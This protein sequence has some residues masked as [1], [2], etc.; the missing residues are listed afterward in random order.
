MFTLRGKLVLLSSCCILALLLLLVDFGAL[1]PFTMR[2]WEAQQMASTAQLAAFDDVLGARQGWL[3][4]RMAQQLHAN[5]SQVNAATAMQTPTNQHQSEDDVLP[6]ICRNT[7]YKVQLCCFVQN[8]ADSRTSTDTAATA[9]F[10]PSLSQPSITQQRV[11]P[12]RHCLKLYN[13]QHI[14]LSAQHSL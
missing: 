14:L 8:P 5:S 4:Q 13:V 7:C 9:S 6:T 3:A 11:G 10:Q 12:A 1:Q 2:S